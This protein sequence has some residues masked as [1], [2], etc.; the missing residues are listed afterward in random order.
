MTKNFHSLFYHP[1][2][3]FEEN[4]KKVRHNVAESE[5]FSVFFFSFVFENGAV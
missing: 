4:R 5:R 3:T 2:H 1:F